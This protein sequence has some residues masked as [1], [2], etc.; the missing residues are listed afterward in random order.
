MFGTENLAAFA[1]ASILLTVTPGQDTF[2]VLGRS[3]AQGR[4]AGVLSALGIATGVLVHVCAAALGLSALLASST[5]A[6]TLVKLTGA[7]YLVYL[8]IQM[9]RDAGE[10]QP[11][12]T[13]AA[14][15]AAGLE[16]YLKGV[17]TNA[18]NPKVALFFLAFLPQFV[19]AGS[20]DKTSSFLFLGFLFLLIG[21]TWC[22]S[23]AVFASAIARGWRGRSRR[24]RAL[25]RVAGAT[26]IALGC[27]LAAERP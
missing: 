20:D 8:G 1:A 21:A 2:Y 24:V 19:S 7:C 11:G 25:R 26:F 13:E 16:I 23:L 3:V 22:V 6:F 17:L 4:R 18:P 5:Y 12:G 9:L 27:K 14:G 15:S 10:V